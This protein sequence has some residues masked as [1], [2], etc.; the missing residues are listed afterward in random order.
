[1]QNSECR[2]K[3]IADADTTTDTDTDPP[4]LAAQTTHDAGAH[5]RH[6][7]QEGRQARGAAPVEEPV[8]SADEVIGKWPLQEWIDMECDNHGWS[9]D[10]C[11]LASWAT[12][13]DAPPSPPSP[14]FSALDAAGAELEVRTAAPLPAGTTAARRAKGALRSQGTRAR[15]AC[16]P[17]PLVRLSVGALGHPPPSKAA[18]YALPRKCWALHR[19][20]TENYA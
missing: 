18:P 5:G 11:S 20:Y 7:L 2:D 14:T 19:L 17:H 12:A 13:A 1:M 4:A 3:N 10:D 6:Q 8:P 16:S 15:T 9:R